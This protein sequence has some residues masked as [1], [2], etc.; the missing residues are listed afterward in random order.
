MNGLKQI[1]YPNKCQR[2]INPDGSEELI[3]VDGTITRIAVDG[4]EVVILPNG[5]REIRSKQYSVTT[6][7][8]HFLNSCL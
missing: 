5:E 4:T 8:V 6:S 2:T 7:Q 1:T 3:M